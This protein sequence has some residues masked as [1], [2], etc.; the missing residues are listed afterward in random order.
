MVKNCVVRNAIDK[1]VGGSVIWVIVGRSVI[2]RWIG[3]MFSTPIKRGS[4]D[5]KFMHTFLK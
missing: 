3:V 1:R 5:S 2:D 4:E